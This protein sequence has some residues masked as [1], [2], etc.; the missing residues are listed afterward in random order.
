MAFRVH[1]AQ[2]PKDVVLIRGYAMRFDNSAQCPVN[3]VGGNE[4]AYDGLVG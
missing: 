1:T 4:N 2:D 3:L